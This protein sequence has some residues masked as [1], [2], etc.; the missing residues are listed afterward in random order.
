M[1]RKISIKH[2]INKKCKSLIKYKSKIYGGMPNYC[3]NK[4]LFQTVLYN[5]QIENWK[6]L[7]CTQPD[8]KNCGPTALKFIFPKINHSHIQDLSVNVETTGITLERFNQFLFEQ[9]IHLDVTTTRLPIVL[10]DIMSFFKTNLLPGYISVIGL[11]TV[12]IMNHITT[13]AKDVNDNIVLFDGQSNMA[14]VNNE[15][16]DYIKKYKFIYVWCSKHKYKHIIDLSSNQSN[17]KMRIEN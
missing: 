8:P 3:G 4:S 15:V 2:K 7:R 6:P 13:I 1:V 14:Y 17:K 12:G 10:Q 16:F 9:I 11:E 5:E